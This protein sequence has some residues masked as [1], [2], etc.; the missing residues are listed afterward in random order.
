M[1][2]RKILLVEGIDDEHVMKHICGNRGIPHLDKVIAHGGAANL[3]ESIPT[4]LR[5]AQEGD[6]FGVVVDANTKIES[7]WHSI[8]NRFTEAGYQDVPAD[9]D[10]NGTIFE[11]PADSILPRAGVWI[12]P[13]NRTPGILEDF[14]YF[15]VPQPNAV[16]DHAIDSVDS[17]PEKYFKGKDRPKAIIHTWL[18]WQKEPGLPYGTAVRARFL[19]P[20]VPEADVLASWLRRLFFQSKDTA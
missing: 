15:M 5:F 20:C 1:A 12:M 10:P 4:R 6:I 3:L 16:L 2:N 7:R 11:P 8:R 17:I 9:P 14:L 13:D 19:D 18:A